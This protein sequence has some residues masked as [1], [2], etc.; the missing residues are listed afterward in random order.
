MDKANKALDSFFDRIKELEKT[1]DA[2]N[3]S[4]KRQRQLSDAA[5]K[6]A[7]VRKEAE[8]KADKQREEVERKYAKYKDAEGKWY[9]GSEPLRKQY[10]DSLKSIN[11]EM[12]KAADADKEAQKAVRANTKQLKEESKAREKALAT[13]QEDIVSV[14]DISPSMSRDMQTY[15]KKSSDAVAKLNKKI[16]ETLTE[17]KVSAESLK[18]SGIAELLARENAKVAADAIARAER[19]VGVAKSVAE[20]QRASGVSTAALQIGAAGGI[21]GLTEI[22]AEVD[23]ITEA[24]M[25][26]YA[27][28][29]PKATEQEAEAYK[30]K[31]IEQSKTLVVDRLVAKQ[32]KEMLEL[33]RKQI[34]TIIRE[35]GV[36]VAAAT[37]IAA[38]GETGREAALLQSRHEQTLAAL[39]K[40]DKDQLILVE[41]MKAEDA[42]AA[43]REAE[44]V[45]DVPVWAQKIIDTYNTTSSTLKDMFSGIFRKEEGWFK[46]IILILSVTIGAAVGYIYTYIQKVFNA[47]KWLSGGIPVLGRLV[48]DL[49]AGVGGLVG[50]IGSAFLSAEKGL[51]GLVKGIPIIGQF[52]SFFPRVLSAL[53]VGFNFVGKFFW[54]LQILI[55]TIDGIIGAFKGFRQLGIKGAIIGAVSQIVSGLTFG[56]LDFQR[57]FDFLN[58]AFGG[59]VDVFVKFAKQTYNLIIKPFVDAFHNIVEIFQGGGNLFS[60]VLKSAVE[61]FLAVVKFLV[62]RIVQTF[63]QIPV[64]L[65][66]A[67]GYVL[68]FV[69]VDIPKMLY[70]AATWV[71]EWI[72]SGV[73]LDDLLSFGTWLND[74]LVGFFT[75]IINSIAD[76]LGE[77]PIVGSH[78]KAA[79]GG[80]TP[81]AAP[82]ASTPRIATIATTPSGGVQVA[83]MTAPM[84]FGAPA[85]MGAATTA[86]TAQ[87]LA[88]N[89]SMGSV[90]N[91]PTTNIVGGGGGGGDG[92]VLMPRTSRNNDPTFRALLFQ[93]APAL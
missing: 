36:S 47:V 88:N 26:R 69:I 19:E 74:K 49:G 39:E 27:V 35:R 29:N 79:L 50:R 24:E 44:A 76:A 93:E 33:K 59:L 86:S 66:N 80:G 23:A 3:E 78:I 12:G 14:R 37:T 92:A 5:A 40:L 51:M 56:L 81:V 87:Y 1:T 13:M 85:L 90:V 28:L 57:V 73:W 63:V 20:Q 11:S 58:D 70:D 52:F 54:P 62:G 22:K 32:E 75:D 7:V 60:K 4:I 18:K 16:D 48:S 89:R 46:T 83:A 67:V 34:E 31:Y 15:L 41:Q 9:A 68:K 91:A 61:V 53:R 82:Q 10:E 21:T 71:Y 8:V 43:E 38:T 55:S 65:L 64:L 2:L 77:I 45:N 25:K 84:A 6:S 17:S 72:T 30:R 42:K